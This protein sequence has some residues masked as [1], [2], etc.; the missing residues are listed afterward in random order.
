[1]VLGSSSS[2]GSLGTGF[3]NAS[4]GFGSGYSGGCG[5]G[6]G[7]YIL[8]MHAEAQFRGN[9]R[10]AVA[11]ASKALQWIR[12]YEQEKRE[13][14]LAKQKL[15]KNNKETDEKAAKELRTVTP[16]HKSLI[17]YKMKKSLSEQDFKNIDEYTT[18]YEELIKNKE[19]IFNNKRYRGVDEFCRAF[20]EV[21]P[22]TNKNLKTWTYQVYR[23]LNNTFFNGKSEEIKYTKFITLVLYGYEFL[24]SGNFELPI[25]YDSLF[26]FKPKNTLVTK[27]D[28]EAFNK[29]KD[30]FDSIALRTDRFDD[31]YRLI[32]KNSYDCYRRIQTLFTKK[33]IFGAPAEYKPYDYYNRVKYE[34][35]DSPLFLDYILDIVKCLPD[36]F[37]PELRAYIKSVTP[38][39]FRTNI[40]LLKLYNNDFSLALLNALPDVYRLAVKWVAYL[41]NNFPIYQIEAKHLHNPNPKNEANSYL[42]NYSERFKKILKGMQKD[43]NQALLPSML[44]NDVYH[45][46]LDNVEEP[47]SKNEL[48]NPYTMDLLNNIIFMRLEFEANSQ[49]KDL[50]YNSVQEKEFKLQYTNPYTIGKTYEEP[51]NDDIFNNVRNIKDVTNYNNQFSELTN[52]L[53]DAVA[54]MLCKKKYN[55]SAELTTDKFKNHLNFVALQVEFNP[56]IKGFKPMSIIK[57]ATKYAT[58]EIGFSADELIDLTGLSIIKNDGSMSKID[59]SS[60]Y[61]KGLQNV[62]DKFISHELLK[63]NYEKL[64]ILLHSGRI[65]V[66]F[67]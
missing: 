33:S 42:N 59:I 66:E 50:A 24:E 16:F 40:F 53:L 28:L 12:E 62:L 48:I 11:A 38:R 4:D 61:T 29:I 37:E 41:Y 21:R 10:Y 52:E 19:L 6:G 57:I 47:F 14:E 49:A 30:S 67:N 63:G 45:T 1:M 31:T 44:S 58:F 23:Y 35:S 34:K 65:S 46:S 54:K 27:N 39:N 32:D 9:V 64:N 36:V 43:Y 25:V 60:T 8:A 26:N 56:Q 51:S 5:F 20:T 3:G 7:D 22:L 55:T 13:K 17:K 15:I 2:F 18:L